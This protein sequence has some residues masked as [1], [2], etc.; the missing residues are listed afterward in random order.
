MYRHHLEQAIVSKGFSASES[1]SAVDKG[2][3]ALD[4]D[5]GT[6]ALD[7]GTLVH[8]SAVSM[9]NNAVK[10]GSCHAYIAYIYTDYC[11]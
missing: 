7:E 2:A 1:A 8:S 5:E 4:D 10:I 3:S 9:W 11:I 6:S